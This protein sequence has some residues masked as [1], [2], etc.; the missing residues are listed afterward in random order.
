M[1][2]SVPL[3][4][5]H[6]VSLSRRCWTPNTPPRLLCGPCTVAVAALCCSPQGCLHGP[7]VFL[8]RLSADQYRRNA[9][10]SPLL[11]NGTSRHRA[12]AP[13]CR[14]PSHHTREWVIHLPYVHPRRLAT[15]SHTVFLPLLMPSYHDGTLIE[16]EL[17]RTSSSSA[18][19]ALP[20]PGAGAHTRTQDVAAH[21]PATPATLSADV[22]GAPQRAHEAEESA[23][24]QSSL[25]DPV[26]APPATAASAVTV[27]VGEDSEEVGDPSA[28]GVAAAAAA[29]TASSSPSAAVLAVAEPMAEWISD[30]P[31]HGSPRLDTRKP[32]SGR[33]RALLCCL[34]VA[35]HRRAVCHRAL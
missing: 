35:G 17:Q 24:A 15:P 8:T 3:R 18:V 5:P 21:A 29:T 27:T 28:D 16:S 23:A 26:S 12:R 14:S 9:C 13:C 33:L 4:G 7:I 20:D 30:W 31:V 2:Q 25:A 11:T 6:A 22:D 34:R 10:L 32:L 1:V 19:V